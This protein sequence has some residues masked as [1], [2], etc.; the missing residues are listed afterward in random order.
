MQINLQFSEQKCSTKSKVQ[1]NK[2]I[3]NGKLF[4]LF[5]KSQQNLHMPEEATENFTKAYELLK[6][7]MQADSA[8]TDMPRIIIRIDNISTSYIFTSE[9]AKAKM[10]LD[11]EDS[12]LAIYRTKP[13]VI[14]KQADMLRGS[15]QLDLAEV[16]EQLGQSEEAARHYNEH[17]KTNYTDGLNE[18]DNPQQQQF[19]DER[20]IEKLT[21]LSS[22]KA[23]DIVEALRTEADRFRPGAEPNDDLTMLCMKLL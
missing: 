10:W 3:T 13:D 7:W 9:Y 5:K 2:Q 17:C 22:Q 23:Q 20:I 6:E 8:G 21:S 11:R 19:G 12:V 15:I 18:A 14:E 16:C 1:I 4:L